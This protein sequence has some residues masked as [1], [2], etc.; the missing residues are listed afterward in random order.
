MFLVNKKLLLF[1]LL[2][3]VS[4]PILLGVRA[5]RLSSDFA[6]LTAAELKL[7]AENSFFLSLAAGV[8][9]LAV[10]L[11]VL[12]RSRDVLRE[13]DKARD[14]ARYAS[15][16]SSGSLRR[17]GTL[18]EK[19]RLL[20]LQL[21]DLNDKKSL[22]I[23]SLSGVIDFMLQV[24]ELPLLISD[25]TGKITQASRKY[26]DQYKL[27]QPDLVGKYLTEVFPD[28]I[29]P[30]VIARLEKEHQA[31]KSGVVKETL[32]LYPVFNRGGEL[33]EVLCVRG[34]DSLL[35]ELAH[36]G[37]EATRTMDRV[38]R[39]IKKQI[40]SAGSPKEESVKRSDS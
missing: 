25:V 28:L 23:S 32:V 40:S 17:L 9:V 33:S 21:A 10:F 16:S 2:V 30:E 24:G 13:L 8:L 26:L 15:F 22:K 38:R 5:L 7:W 18:G 1:L 37:V 6:G 12:K 27:N 19:I 14:L 34:R 4:G 31:L 35:G 36:V 3:A 29:W 39:F 20:Y 11:A